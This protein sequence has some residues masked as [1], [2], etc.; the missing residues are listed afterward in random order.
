M[1]LTQAQV[2]FM[3][4]TRYFVFLNGQET[5]YIVYP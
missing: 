5:W 4:M 2:F 3:H 1:D